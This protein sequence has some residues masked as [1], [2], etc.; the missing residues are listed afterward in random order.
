MTVVKLSDI[1]Y[2]LISLHKFSQ[3]FLWNI[4]SFAKFI[5]FTIVRYFLNQR[6][7]I[8]ILFECI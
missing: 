8:V 1:I 7:N 2:N 4:E 3:W 6:Q 5:H